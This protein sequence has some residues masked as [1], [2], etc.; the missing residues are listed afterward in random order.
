MSSTRDLAA[1]DTAAAVSHEAEAA[2]A[3]PSAGVDPTTRRPSAE[4]VLAA[5]GIG[6]REI[7]HLEALRTSVRPALDGR[8]D[9]PPWDGAA[10]S[11]RFVDLVTGGPAVY[12]TR[13]ACLWDDEA[14]YVGFRVE[15][16]FL[17]A[18]LIERDALIWYEND[19][20][21]FVAGP[22]ACWEL[23]LNQLGTIY[24]VLHVWA[25][26]AREGGSW[27]VPAYDPRTRDARG[28]TGNGDPDRWDWDGL[29]PRGHRWAFLDWDLSGLKVAVA[30]D[31]T[32]NDHSDVDRG[33]SAELA[34]PWSAL[35]EV[36][37]GPKAVQRSAP[38]AGSTL[39][40]CFA[41]YENFTLGGR[42]V[43]PAT[44]WTLNRHGRYDIHVPEAFPIVHLSAQEIALQQGA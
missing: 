12:D 3:G 10:W 7:T 6:E 9:G 42:P 26:A 1:A 44:G 21:L 19:V 36:I 39:R 34:V 24:E 8:T 15:E 29:H 5:Y 20:E 18:S 11:S 35:R 2:P 31:G 13:V 41:R 23:E 27:H 32:L 14:L 37:D 33:W 4:D 40:C 16:P 28:F 25:D 17:E 30:L 43:T 38:R 22:D